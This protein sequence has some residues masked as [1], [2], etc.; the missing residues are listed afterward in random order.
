MTA[1]TCMVAEVPGH[2]AAIQAMTPEIVRQ[3]LE[4]SLD[5]F[6]VAAMKTGMLHGRA[7]SSR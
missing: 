5:A 4:L 1:V 3:Q 7:Q 6:P 2:V